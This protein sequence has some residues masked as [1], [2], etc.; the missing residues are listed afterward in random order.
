[1][2]KIRSN[3]AK[4]KP[5]SKTAALTAF[6]LLA[7]VLALSAPASAD[8]A[9]ITQ[10]V[11]IGDSYSAGYGVLSNDQSAFG[12][13][14]E[15]PDYQNPSEVP[16]GRL[17][18]D[19]DV[20]LEFQA[21]GG[22][23][24][25]DVAEQ[26]RTAS[27]SIAGDGSGT[28]IVL[29]AGGNDVR[30]ERGEMWTDLILRCIVFEFNCENSSENR[31]T[32]FVDVRN[33][34]AALVDEI[35]T[36]APGAQIRVLGYPELLQRSPFCLGVTGVDGDEADFLD[37]AARRLNDNLEAGV[38]RVATNRGG[39]IEFVN[40]EEAFDDHGAC[41]THW[42]GRRFV[43][44]TVVRPWPTLVAINSFHPTARG[45][46]AYSQELQESLFR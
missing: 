1:M 13:S 15:D 19:L 3:V 44:D 31:V 12:G 17:A 32:N 45:Y 7:S 26:F 25:P 23:T 46:D 39:D 33:S 4:V 9:G 34:M 6:T 14:C 41:Q 35:A 40:V 29:T 10:V 11:Q 42:S 5:W 43:N 28:V 36:T 38:N 21:C 16:G 24:I 30:T 27:E 18:A 8:E 37:R 22:A 20:P 2:D